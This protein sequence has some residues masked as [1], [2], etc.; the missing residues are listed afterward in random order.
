[1]TRIRTSGPFAFQTSDE[2]SN[3]D[4]GEST[5]FPG[6]YRFQNNKPAASPVSSPTTYS[7]TAG[8]QVSS[9]QIGDA[10]R[11]MDAQNRARSQQSQGYQ[12]QSRQPQQQGGQQQYQQMPTIQMQMADLLQDPAGLGQQMQGVGQQ[13]G[14]G[15]QAAADRMTEAGIGPLA[16][17]SEKNPGPYN[18]MGPAMYGGES[19]EKL[20]KQQ[21]SQSMF[22][23]MFNGGGF[24][25]GMMPMPNFTPGPTPGS[26]A[27]DPFQH[28]REYDQYQR[29]KWS[30][31]EP[32]RNQ[33]LQQYTPLLSMIFGRGGQSQF[34][35]SFNSNYG[36]S[37]GVNNQQS[38]SPQQP[39]TGGSF[40]NQ[41]FQ[42]Y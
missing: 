15:L 39:A 40:I 3:G 11:M 2:Y 32:M 4:W 17:Y 24:G 41:A 5:Q 35:T 7:S 37:A 31:D 18:Y 26:Y 1:M 33:M 8:N 20:R 36:A 22:G 38:R 10:R 21:E 12:Q 23:G 19:A 27:Q 34:P 25:G 28:M 14:S 29:Q 6:L 13:I 30:T 16:P 42:R 9:Q